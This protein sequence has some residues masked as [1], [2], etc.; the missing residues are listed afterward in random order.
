M[1]KE[2][3]LTDAIYLLR[4]SAA[5]VLEGR[6]LEPNIIELD[7]EE[8]WN[9]EFMYLEWSE[10][11][12]T[13]WDEETEEVLETQ[14]VIC[15][16]VFKVGDNQKCLLDGCVLTMVSDQGEE[17]LTLLREFYPEIK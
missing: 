3:S 1:Q 12:P 2:I 9:S 10:D 11:A 5:V 6:L 14:N 13:D 7:D 17:E 4:Q 15:E 16:V 8:D